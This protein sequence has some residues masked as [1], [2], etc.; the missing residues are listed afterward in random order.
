MARLLIMSEGFAHKVIEL[1]LGVNRFGRTKDNDFQIDHPTISAH[2]CEI[3]LSDQGLTLRDC[4]S[5]NGTFLA[6]EPVTNAVLASGQSLRLGDVE[7]L[8]ENTEINVAIPKF[9]MPRPAPPVVLTDGSIICPRHPEAQITHRCTNCQEV[10]CDTCVRR[11]RR[12]GGKLLKLCPICSH[13]CEPLT[14][15]K[16]KKRGLFGLLHK[17]VKLPFVH[18]RKIAGASTDADAPD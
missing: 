16:K 11:L 4:D 9:E 5:T 1:H 10:M 8:V 12:R 7:F 13:P 14:P 17:T 18:S 6:G 3:A 2:H 15:E